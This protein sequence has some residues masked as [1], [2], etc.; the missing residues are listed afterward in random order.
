LTVVLAPLNVTLPQLKMLKV[1]GL[2]VADQIIKMNLHRG[3][4]LSQ[5]PE[6]PELGLQTKKRGKIAFC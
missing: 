1:W 2:E 3:F 5:G 4:Q 6:S